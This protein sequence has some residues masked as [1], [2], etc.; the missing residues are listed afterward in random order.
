ME[1]QTV[2]RLADV[3]SFRAPLDITGVDGTLLLR[4]LRDM[5]VIRYAEERIGDMV[6]EGKVRCPCH[7]G[8]GQEAIAVGVSALLRHT[9]RVFGGHRS[10]SHFLALGGDP[11]RLFAE[12]LGRVD[13][14][15]GGMGGSMHLVDE[16]VGFLGSVPIV[17][18][19]VPLAVGAALSAKRRKLTDVAVCYF[20]DG[21]A[22]EGVVHESLNF[23]ATFG[24]PVLFVCENNFFSSHLHIQQ[25]Q[26]DISVARFAQAHR[27]R[28]E[29]VDG[30]D[31]VAVSAATARLVEGARS[32][33]GPGFLEAIT[34]RWRG[35][36]GPREDIDVGVAR[37]ENHAAWKQRDPVRRLVDALVARGELT[38]ERHESLQVEVR[39]LIHDA[40]ARAETSPFPAE[41][42]LLDCVFARNER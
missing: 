11:Y 7:L 29:I 27:I 8:I 4:Q 14:A 23:A 19:T 24:L 2:E 31:V 22:E 16:A 41:S 25:R 28:T 33:E 36:V 40:W 21:A 30:N 13:G 12:V 5:L 1:A 6:T 37:K 17:A 9:D 39:R 38:V 3:E 32:G 15:S 20:G 18:A 35:H 34:Y 26:P 42:A 10:H